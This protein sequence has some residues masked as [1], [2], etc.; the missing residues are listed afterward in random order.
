MTDI[1]E[2]IN[3]TTEDT[4]EDKSKKEEDFMRAAALAYARYLK[5]HGLAPGDVSVEEDAEAETETEPETEESTEAEVE[6][7]TEEATEEVTD[8]VAT[9]EE[10]ESETEVKAEEVP[11][12]EK[13]EEPAEEEESEKKAEEKPAE[14]KD[15]KGKSKKKEEER[16]KYK[17][18]FEKKGSGKDPFVAAINLHDK[19]QD[20]IDEAAGNIGRDFARG[21]HNIA[22]TYRNTRKTIGLGILVMGI[23]AAVLLVVFDRFTVYEY[24]YN[25]KTLGYVK[26]QEEVT[27]V[28]DVAGRKLTQNTETGAKV[29]FVAN[30]NVTFNP[31]DG[32]GKSTDDADTAVNKLI[33]MTDIETEAYGVYDGPQ[34]KAIV[35]DQ[36]DAERLL[37][38]T[39]AELS[40]PDDGMELV[41]SD[42]LNPLEIRPVNVLLGSVQSNQAARRQMIDGGKMEVYHIVDSADIESPD[43]QETDT[44]EELQSKMIAALADNFGVDTASLYDENNRDVITSVEAGDVVCIR[45]TVDPVSVRM[46][47]TGRIKETIE[48]KTIKK[49]SD[50]YYQGDTYIEQEGK[51]GSRIFEGT[52]TKVAGEEESR[53]TISEEITKEPKDKIILIGTKE[54]PKTAATG[55]FQMPIKSYVVTSEYGGRWGRMHDGMDFGAPTGTTI[56]A[57]DG[58]TVIRASYYGGYGN[59]IEIDHEN[60][61]VTRYAHCSAI[62]VSAGDKVY[63]GQEIGRVGNTGHSFGSHLHFEVR[64]NGASQNP[65]NYV[66]P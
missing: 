46:V 65:R 12:A 5:E 37:E 15:A 57:A 4:S 56:Y 9:D 66:N 31:V 60:G 42:F 55:T 20:K 49:E 45:S 6:E 39:K 8:E 44:E 2:L 54:R 18:Y 58:G 63:Q 28:L 26:E 61:H 19:I 7:H 48:Y 29:E 40:T 11:E 50:E 33:Y 47:E 36:E 52:I 38:E 21:A 17:K 64:V 10:A 3:G 1:E 27:D 30:Q 24:A 32:R 25:G 16:Q 59:C 14:K 51:N 35:K 43:I 34:L 41:S 62:L 53:E 13:V 22:S 23:L